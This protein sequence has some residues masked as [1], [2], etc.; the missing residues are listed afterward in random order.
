MKMFLLLFWGYTAL[1]LSGCSILELKKPDIRLE[2]VKINNVSFT[3]MALVVNL[4]VGNPNDKDVRIDSIQYA[5]DFNGQNLN[6]EKI[7]G[8]WS[9]PKKSSTEISLPVK[10]KM[11]NVLES[12]NVLKAGEN[13]VKI[14]GEAIINSMRVPFKSEKKLRVKL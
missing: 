14:K 2:A 5:L 1:C 13:L 11:N 7:T 10:L 4:V 8:P 6:E 12:L 3:E 9:F